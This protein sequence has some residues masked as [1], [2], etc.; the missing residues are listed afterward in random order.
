MFT[1]SKLNGHSP[2]ACRLNLISKRTKSITT[3]RKSVSKLVNLPSLVAKY[4]KIAKHLPK[5][6]KVANF[7][8]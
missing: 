6:V 2:F 5:R 1:Y 3:A 4:F 8:H 7:A